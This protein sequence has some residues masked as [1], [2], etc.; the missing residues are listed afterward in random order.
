[1]VKS[2]VGGMEKRREELEEFYISTRDS[3]IVEQLKRKRLV[4]Q[5]LLAAKNFTLIALWL[6]CLQQVYLSNG[7]RDRV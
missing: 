1:M 4:Q 5:I 2:F 6:F 7:L 3:Q